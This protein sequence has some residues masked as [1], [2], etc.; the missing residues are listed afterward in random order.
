MYSYFE[1]ITEYEGDKYVKIEMLGVCKVTVEI[2]NV[3]EI[4][5][6]ES[7]DNAFITVEL[8]E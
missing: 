4:I 6:S 3:V 7:T 1:E 2:A 5:T 8:A